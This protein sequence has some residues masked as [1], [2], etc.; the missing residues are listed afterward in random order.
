[1]SKKSSNAVGGE[2]C[3]SSRHTLSY[4]SRE[5]GCMHSRCRCG[6]N[7][8]ESRSIVESSARL[9]HTRNISVAVLQRE[10]R[11]RSTAASRRT[12]RSVRASYSPSAIPHSSKLLPTGLDFAAS[13][14]ASC[15]SWRAFVALK[16]APSPPRPFSPWVGG[17]AWSPVMPSRVTSPSLATS[18]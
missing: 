12:T 6:V 4:A 9:P 10:R 17:M 3:M 14:M 16:P 1:M 15:S 11:A 18:T 2:E 8:A 13:P 7:R 5:G